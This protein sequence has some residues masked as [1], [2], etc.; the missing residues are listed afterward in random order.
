MKPNP[1]E[2]LKN[3]TVPVAIEASSEIATPNGP[4]DRRAALI[5]E[6]ASTWEIWDLSDM[7]QSRKIARG[8][9]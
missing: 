8:A 6:I 7:G 9:H 1:L 2:V 5:A 4:A 3:L